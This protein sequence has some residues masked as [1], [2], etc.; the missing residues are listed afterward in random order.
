M[1]KSF[2]SMLRGVVL[3]LAVF[4][5]VNAKVLGGHSDVNLVLDQFQQQLHKTMQEP[6]D[7]LQGLKIGD[8]PLMKA[9]KGMA[10]SADSMKD[11]VKDLF[12]TLAT[13]HTSVINAGLKELG[14]SIDLDN[15]EEDV[16]ALLG[17]ECEEPAFSPPEE[18][19]PTLTG[20][21]FTFSIATGGCEIERKAFPLV[22]DFIIT[23]STP[24][25]SLE[26]SPASYTGK[27]MA[28]AS[29]TT[30]ECKATRSYGPSFETT[31]PLFNPAEYGEDGAIGSGKHLQKIK[32]KLVQS[33]NWKGTITVSD[34]KPEMPDFHGRV[35]EWIEL[36]QELAPKA[37]GTADRS[38]AAM[39]AKAQEVGATLD[40]HLTSLDKHGLKNSPMVTQ[41][42][43]AVANLM[44]AMMT[45]DTDKAFKMATDNLDNFM[46]DGI[47]TVRANL[48][49]IMENAF[50]HGLL[51]FAEDK[52]LRTV[53]MKRLEDF[54]GSK[55]EDFDITKP[56]HSLLKMTQFELPEN[57][58][59][60]PGAK[61]DA[62][63]GKVM[64]REVVNEK[65]GGIFTTAFKSWDQIHDRINAIFD[66]CEE[67]EDPKVKAAGAS[68]PAVEPAMETLIEYELIKEIPSNQTATP[69]LNSTNTTAFGR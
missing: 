42:A 17:R 23:C 27:Y 51:K 43:A 18:V 40:Q 55:L 66:L 6:L 28:A 19:P 57:I 5:T 22:K 29:A 37:R 45:G 48:Q 10:E 61:C 65:L 4:S 68:E 60:G 41:G 31:V 62:N 69:A 52:G 32:E 50:S 63:N 56:V 64:L 8:G 11:N 13:A 39:I 1:S 9:L 14:N 47:S 36:A 21:S 35:K 54:F 34:E 53:S 38:L 24:S 49:G 2:T 7:K 3:C 67:E 26:T 30:K 44:G 46:A 20:P 15:W 58:T 25:V 59:Y 33:L 12:G 16:H